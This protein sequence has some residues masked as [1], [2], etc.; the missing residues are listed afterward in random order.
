MAN[1]LTRHL[2]PFLA[3]RL[4][5]QAEQT[6]SHKGIFILP[7]GF[8]LAWLLLTLLL[9]LLGTNYQNNLI[10]G[11][12]LLLSSLFVTCMI[13]SYRNLE[14]VTL[15]RR[16]LPPIYA[17]ETL[18]MPLSV[19]AGRDV[20]QLALAYPGVTPV[21]LS[22]FDEDASVL[23][24]IPTHQRGL[25]NPGRLKV[26]SRF[27]LGLMRTWIWVDL[28]IDHPVFANHLENKIPP[29]SHAQD[30]SENEAGILV[31]GMDEYQGLRTYI[32]GESLKQVAWKQLAQG[33]G[34]LSKDFGRPQGAPEWLNLDVL[35][36]GTLEERLSLLSYWVDELAA[37]QQVYGLILPG[38]EIPPGSGENHRLTCQTAMA[39]FDGPYRHNWIGLRS[40]YDT[41]GTHHSS[42]DSASINKEAAS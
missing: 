36:E 22:V 41:P 20:H 26:E 5:P 38:V 18:A 11:V 29:F 3:K 7:S 31:T 34:M 16:P 28:A 14:G 24:P 2:E 32:P 13:Y 37:R 12:A 21:Y 6:L 35:Q 25:L 4:P 33:R 8:G 1:R 27:P 19:S 9:Y 15:K 10:L 17:G 30:G 42:V 39:T 23:V 40:L